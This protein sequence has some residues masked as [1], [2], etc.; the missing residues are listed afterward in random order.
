MEGRGC[1]WLE[2][3]KKHFEIN[4]EFKWEPLK[5]LQNRS[6]VVSGL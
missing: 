5:L 2:W 1:G 3:P 6:D 4:V